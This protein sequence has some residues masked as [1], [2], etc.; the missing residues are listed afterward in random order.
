MEVII[1]LLLEIVLEGLL[2]LVFEA[3]WRGAD[4]AARDAVGAARHSHARQALGLALTTAAAV[5]IGMWRGDAVDGIGWGWWVAVAIGI[6]AVGG[7]VF[8]TFHPAGPRPVRNATLTW[9]PRRR[10][11]WFAVANAAFIA[12]YTFTALVVG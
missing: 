8:R 6:V 7:A 5:V 12:G 3:G 11:A 1:E 10:C 4:G 9:W 2:Q